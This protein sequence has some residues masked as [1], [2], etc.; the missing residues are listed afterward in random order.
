MEELPV[1]VRV[2]RD[3][4]ER[5]ALDEDLARRVDARVR[6]VG[7]LPGHRLKLPVERGRPYDAP[8]VALLIPLLLFGLAALPQ[9]WLGR[10]VVAGGSALMGM[11]F[12]LSLAAILGP[13]SDTS[14]D[15]S[16]WAS[17]DGHPLI[18]AILVAEVACAA[19]LAVFAVRPPAVTTLRVAL[20]GSGIASLVLLVVLAEA[21]SN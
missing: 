10:S 2:M 18:V 4:A 21:L 9:R 6:R 20:V 17:H 12:A 16:N 8:P 1:P 14:R 11:T 13:N 19:L 3:E 5:L 7:E 15:E